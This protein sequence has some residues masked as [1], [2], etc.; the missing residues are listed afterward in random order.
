M[1]TAKRLLPQ[2]GQSPT[3]IHCVIKPFQTIPIKEMMG[4]CNLALLNRNLRHLINLN[5]P[6]SLEQQ[7]TP[8]NKL[9]LKALSK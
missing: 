4:V 8:L 3:G 5:I 7:T 9:L 1:T 2:G 6:I